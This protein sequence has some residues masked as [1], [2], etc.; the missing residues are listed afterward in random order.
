MHVWLMKIGELPPLEGSGGRLYRTGLIAQ[1]L[2]DRGHTVTWWNS[3]LDHARKKLLY[4]TD[5]RVELS[6]NYTLRLLHSISYSGNI[7]ARRILNH[8]HVA[9]KFRGY[10]EREARPDC[11]V[12]CLPTL[13]L[14]AA[15]VGYGRRHGVPVVLDIRDLWPDI[16][17]DIAPSSLRFAARAVLSPYYRMARTALRGSQGI[18]GISEDYLRWGLGYAGRERSPQD[19]VFPL[20]YQRPNV[21]E[22]QIAAAGEN[23]TAAGVDINRT[24]CWFVGMFGRT[25]DLE[26]VIAAAREAANSGLHDLQFVL[27]GAGENYDRLVAQASSLDNVVF[28][29]RIDAPGLAWMAKQASIGLMAY[30]KGAPQSLPNKL[31][32]YLCNGLPVLSSLEG[33]TKSLLARHHCGLS[34]A[35]GDVRNLVVQLGS[36][37]RDKVIM[38][39][40][41]VNGA[42]LFDARYS[43]EKIYPE[44]VSYLER[45]SGQ[46]ASCSPEAL[47]QAAQDLH[48]GASESS[49][50]EPL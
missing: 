28:T 46:G 36:I 41:A 21:D 4:H 29:G 23:L 47:G 44:L 24:I 34:Y 5:A 32:E 31:F 8:V 1:A 2:V 20:G 12:C 9:R 7:S 39:E 14:C 13:E 26:T 22:K 49:M 25:Y 27:S 45:V 11:I 50:A 10:A 48:K 43:V 17:L 35:A 37:T 3:T 6:R 38:R 19:V 15:A 33:E 30:A 42:Q 16:F 18:I 40:M